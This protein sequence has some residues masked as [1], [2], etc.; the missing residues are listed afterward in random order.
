MAAHEARTNLANYFEAQRFEIQ[1]LR[2]IFVRILQFT[3]V[4]GLSLPAAQLSRHM[5]CVFVW[6]I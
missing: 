5:V 1:Y 6:T 2:N 4:V 3:A